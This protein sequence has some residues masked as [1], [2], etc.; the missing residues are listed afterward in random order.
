M[1]KTLAQLILKK[2]GYHIVKSQVQT[3]GYLLKNID[4]TV[5]E[6]IKSN[7][8]LCD[9]R[10]INIIE[11]T[12]YLIS[13]KIAGDFIECG[14]WKGGAVATMAN[15]L[16]L[17]SDYRNVHLFDAFDD[18][19]EPDALL[20][21]QRAI[22][23]VGGIENAQGR[24]KPINGIYQKMGKEGP[25]NERHVLELLKN[26]IKYPEDKIFIHKGWFQDT[27]PIAAPTINNI[28]LLR[29]DGDWYAST[30]V[31]LEFLY[32]KVV[33]GGVII[34]DDYLT[35]EG[36]KLAVDEFLLSRNESPFMFR[37]NSDCVCWV[38]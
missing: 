18:I 34:I 10:L 37:V 30:K 19:C 27:L 1:I 25:G 4:K 35:Y 22:E 7:S 32:D 16:K 23:E 26:I 6:A 13:K 12:N 17:A 2:F 38:K 8:M 29:L 24:L 20:D 28:A 15:A 36:C 14:V 33:Q 5:L 9:A 3:D 31:C 11:A 21:G